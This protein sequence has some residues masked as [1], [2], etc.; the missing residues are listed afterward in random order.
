MMRRREVLRDAVLHGA[1]VDMLAPC[2]PERPVQRIAR[3]E[4]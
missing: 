3:A 1:R 4:G 2:R